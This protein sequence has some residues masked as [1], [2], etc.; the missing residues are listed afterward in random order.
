MSDETTDEEL[1]ALVE[2]YVKEHGATHS[3]EVAKELGQDPWRVFKS[4]MRLVEA[5]K[6][7]RRL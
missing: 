4:G 5:R 6:P 2:A 7:G 1:D 3:S